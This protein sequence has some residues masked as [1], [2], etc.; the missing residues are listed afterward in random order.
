MAAPASRPNTIR[1]R[2]RLPTS[3]P[4]P[5]LRLSR[6]KAKA[7]ARASPRRKPRHRRKRPPPKKLRLRRKLLHPRQRAISRSSIWTLPA[8]TNRP[9]RLR[10]LRCHRRRN[11]LHLRPPLPR[12]LLLLRPPLPHRLRPRLPLPPPPERQPPHRPP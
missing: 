9:L 6:P 2:S 1:L 8:A 12:H 11:P 3:G 7:R 10:R 4:K 5:T